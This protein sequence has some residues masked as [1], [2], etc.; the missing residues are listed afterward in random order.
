MDAMG[1]KRIVMQVTADGNAS[2]DFLGT[3]GHITK[4]LIPSDQ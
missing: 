2:L 4:S 1:R 3:D